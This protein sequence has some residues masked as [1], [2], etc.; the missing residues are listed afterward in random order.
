MKEHRILLAFLVMILTLLSCQND[1]AFY[2]N[3]KFI[4]HDS[5]KTGIRFKNVIHDLKR[6]NA[7]TYET[8]YSGGGVAIGDLNNDGLNDVY[9][10]GNQVGD[11]LYIN[12]GDFNFEEVT[13]QSGII[14]DGTWSTGITMVDI[15]KDGWLDIYICKSLYDEKPQLRKN[16]L[17]INQQNG[18]FID[19]AAKY[20][21]D[22]IWRTQEACFFD[23]DN[24]SDLDVVLINQPPNPGPLSP[25]KGGDYRLPEL[26][27][28]F[29]ENKN[30]KF[31]DQTNEV[32]LA[33]SGYALSASITDFNNDGWLDM[34]I[35]HDYNSPDKLYLNSGNKSF[36]DNT[37]RSCKQISF[38]SMGTDAADINNDGFEDFIVADMVASDPYRNKANM[39]GMNPKSFWKVVNNGGNYQY[40]YNSLQLNVGTENNISYFSN[41]SQFAGLSKTD[42]SWSPLI[43]DFDNDGFK[44][45]F[46]SNGIKRD[47]RFT[48]GVS[49]IKN[50]ISKIKSQNKISQKELLEYSDPIKLLKNL[51]SS[52]L[53]NFIF[54]NKDGM[55]F[56]NKVL[57]W[58][59]DQNSFS[60]GS[61]IGDL[62]NDGD[63]DLIVNNV[64]DFP[65][66]Y[67]N[68]ISNFNSLRIEIKESAIVNTDI[69]GVKVNVY[70]DG[71]QLSNIGKTNQGFYS[72]S[73]K[74]V[75]F[76]LGKKNRID[77]V[78][79]YWDNKSYS[80]IT[81]V[82]LNE[83]NTIYKSECKLKPRQLKEN[84][85][86]TPIKNLASDLNLKVKHESN[87]FDD[88]SKQVLLPYQISKT[89]QPFVIGDFDGDN[90]EDIL[91]AHS[92]ASPPKLILQNGNAFQNGISLEIGEKQ[93]I[94][95]DIIAA[96]FDEDGDLDAY[97]SCGGN[98]FENGDNKYNNYFLINKGNGSFDFK[99]DNLLS[100]STNK[101]CSFDF[102]SDGD[103]DILVSSKFIP[104]NYPHPADLYLLENLSSKGLIEFKNIS[105][106]FDFQNLGLINDILVED[107]NGDNQKDIVLA[108][109]WMPITIFKNENNDFK[110][111]IIPNSIGWWMSVS[112]IDFNKDGLKDLLIGNLGNNAKY[113][114]NAKDA[115]YT[116]F[117]DFDNNG[118]S[119][120]ILAYGKDNKEFPVRGRSCSSE[121]IPSLKNKFPSYHQ[122][123]SNDLVGIYGTKL[124]ESTKIKVDMFSSALLKNLGDFSFEIQE[125]PEKL[126]LSAIKDIIDLGDQ[127]F[128][129]VGNM[130]YMEIE[131]PKI[132]GSYGS[133]FQI[134]NEGNIEVTRPNVSSLLSGQ[135]DAIHSIKKDNHEFLIYIPIDDSLKVFN[136]STFKLE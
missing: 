53:T 105:D 97:V 38:F 26:G 134:N 120:I 72:C 50:E 122:F 101:S 25:L 75:H 91:L 29:L 13:L 61:A 56:S 68:K 106:K 31:I 24:D 111:D 45:V 81:D 20:G 2:N 64:D 67:E 23:Y 82:V 130:N 42:W 4:L 55:R 83:I 63:L 69:N 84:N 30:G 44:D 36:E 100:V 74:I 96:D 27:I 73:E 35:A 110:K 40:M 86:L 12:K 3:G 132:D 114:S 76:G 15:N 87:V 14:N 124:N 33:H 52:K 34:Y 41:I 103:L 136:K 5:E 109:E 57:D 71:I 113:K 117:E 133:V 11:A 8:F 62:D 92:I 43:A 18:K 102:D 58:G 21:L 39:G 47:L 89:H 9:L 78:L 77:S 46:I 54:K 22:D 126:Q 79:I 112:A 94:A 127:N 121:Q 98:K 85:K 10:G 123:A 49:E 19:Q 95:N 7:L 128:L 32:G 104:G 66:I 119:D 59:V 115:F 135:I 28:R 129:S 116:Y 17:Y 90:R 80:K 16:K 70:S 108:G 65:F 125:F 6:H 37:N 48:D 51:P 60:N 93:S 107:I 131:T 1:P 118:Q 99:P 88:F